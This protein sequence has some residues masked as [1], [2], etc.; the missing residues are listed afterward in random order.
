LSVTEEY[1][2]YDHSWHGKAIPASVVGSHVSWGMGIVYGS[3]YAYAYD[4]SDHA[5]HGKASSGTIIDGR[6]HN[7]LGLVWGST[8]AY[9]Y[10]R[11]TKSWIG[12]GKPTPITRVD[13]SWDSG[14]L[15]YIC[16]LRNVWIY[17]T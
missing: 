10:D 3:T 17:Q 5:W 8:F 15:A 11:A 9:A 13:I 6:S 7:Q 1:D 4:T 2:T 16:H 12:K 14:D